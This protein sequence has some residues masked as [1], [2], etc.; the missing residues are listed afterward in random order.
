MAGNCRYPRQSVASRVLS[1]LDTF[2]A[3]RT[4]LTLSEVCRRTGL[5]A[6]TAHRMLRELVTWGALERTE[7][8]RYVV[9]LRLWEVG[10]LAPRGLGLREV[11]MPFLE[12]LYEATHEN[13]QL[14]VL[15]GRDALYVEKISG[16]HAVGLVNR[17]GGRLP[18]HAT[19]VGR[20]LLAFAPPELGEDVLA[21]DLKRFT[22]HTVVAPHRLRRILAD[23]RRLGIAVCHEQVSLGAVSIA[24]PIW[25]RESSVVAAL[26]VVIPVGDDPRVVAPAVRA[27][28]R[29]ISR[30]LGARMSVLS[31]A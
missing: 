21:S 13:V 26:S 10:A 11:A 14:A 17:V 3:D 9:G 5:P 24:A 2:T 8:G 25:G 16:R 15:D 6:S 23:V 20:V 29:G 7:E 27:A 19:G 18:L 4:A 12:D 1:I 30:S 28:A 22:E 31:P